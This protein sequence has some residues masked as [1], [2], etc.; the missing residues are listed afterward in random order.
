MF[1]LTLITTFLYFN[2]EIYSMSFGGFYSIM[3]A[4]DFT[5]GLSFF[6]EYIAAIRFGHIFYLFPFII[7]IILTRFK[8][9]SF[10]VEYSKLKQPLFLLLMG[11]LFFFVSLQTVDKNFEENEGE[12]TYSD[13]ELYTY[14]YNAQSAIKKFGLLTY[15]QRDFFS[16]FGADPLSESEHEILIDNFL[17]NQRDRHYINEYSNIFKNKNLILIMAESFDNFAINES[18]TPNLFKL[19]QNNASFENFYAPLYYRSTAD[20]EF[21]VQTSF[22]P[23]KNV[24]LSMEAYIDNNFP[25]TM[26]KLFKAEGYSTS[27][28]HNYTDYFYP[29]SKFH[30][31]TLGYDNYYGSEEL[32]LL[33]NPKDNDII[34]DH[35]WQSDLEMMKLALPKFINEDK[36]FV[37]FITVSGHL[38]YS[39]SHNIAQ[40]NIDI[41]RQ[42][43]ID[44]GIELPSEIA[45]Y[46]AANIELDK[47]I[48]YLVDSLEA[49]DRLNDTVIMIF[50]DHYPYGIDKDTIWNYDEVKE[51]GSDSDIHNVPM[52]ISSTSKTLDGTVSNYMSTVDVLP[53]VSNLFGLKLDYTKVFGKDALSSDNNIV[54]FADM[55]YVSSDFSYDSLSEEYEIL[56]DDITLNYLV[57]QS[58]K[59]N[60]QYT[61]NLSILEYDYFKMDEEE[62]ENQDNVT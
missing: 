56:N 23:D 10:N 39:S 18:L 14:M 25:Y 44:N 59:M 11:S 60:T 42:Y 17:E 27:S 7:L 22:Y 35:K 32:G 5:L 3:V 38:R 1:I 61:Y 55:S 54:R 6:N 30:S 51:D 29:R 49:A 37:N 50:G 58:H 45:Y 2:Q 41:I 36:F 57:S 26:P 31:E 12:L 16:L 20:T 33:D 62:E 43:E 52:I 21:M 28:F 34:F 15:T 40:R 13:M 24:T 19:Q 53:T 9:I 47:S 8:V 4:G 48:G 46:L